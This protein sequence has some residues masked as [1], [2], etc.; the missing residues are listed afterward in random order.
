MSKASENIVGYDSRLL[1]MSYDFLDQRR[2]DLLNAPQEALVE[3]VIA[4][5]KYL[6]HAI[7]NYENARYRLNVS[8]V[9]SVYEDLKED[10][11]RY[12]EENN[13]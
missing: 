13:E 7:S 1:S 6:L 5:E 10:L 11:Y 4:T 8:D 12:E 2:E 9:E 3:K